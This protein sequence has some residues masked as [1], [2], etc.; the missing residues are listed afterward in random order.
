MFLQI[1]CPIYLVPS[2]NLEQSVSDSHTAHGED[3]TASLLSLTPQKFEMDNLLSSESWL[4]SYASLSKMK[5]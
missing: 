1:R 3:H 5:Q 2:L 4:P